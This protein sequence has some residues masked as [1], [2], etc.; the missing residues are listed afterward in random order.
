MTKVLLS[1]L[2][3]GLLSSSALAGMDKVARIQEGLKK[4]QI[5]RVVASGSKQTVR[6]YYALNPDCITRGSPEVRVTKQPEHGMVETAP[7]QSFPSYPKDNIRFKCNQQKVRGVQVNYKSADKYVG[8]DE[9]DLLVLFPG[10]MASEVHY[11]ISVR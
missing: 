9:F 10:G 2:V 3:V 4:E 6:F 5:T 7:V 11:D 1:V 8:D